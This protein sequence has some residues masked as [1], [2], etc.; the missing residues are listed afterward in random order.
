M[1]NVRNL[2]I[3]EFIN[4]DE[5][6][7][8]IKQQSELTFNGIHKSYENCDSYSIKLNE[9]VM[10]K[11]IYFGF[12]VLELGKLHMYEAFYDMLQ[13]Y[14]GQENIQLHYIDTDVFVLSVNTHDI[15]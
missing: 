4:K 13:P 5:F 10:D 3:I 8:I 7:K 1:E 6:K 11:P 14:F 2:F 9:V 15:I 12:A